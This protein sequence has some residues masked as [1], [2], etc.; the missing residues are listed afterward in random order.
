MALLAR[1]ADSLYWAG[2]Y[3]ERAEDTA[4]IV[5]SY[6]EAVVDLPRT[7]ATSW[8][9]LL[10]ITGVADAAAAGEHAIVRHLVADT[11]NPASIAA[12][13]AAAREN[14]RTTREVLPRDAWR[15]LNDLYLYVLGSIDDGVDR[16]SRSRVL[17]TVV[18]SSRR[19]D[20]IVDSCMSHDEAYQM[21]RLGRTIERADM[22]T[23]VLGVRAAALL[24]VGDAADF[25]G[26]LW[27]SVLRSLSA[28]QMYQRSS[29]R[30]VEGHAVV[31]FLLYD[32]HFPRSVRACL[33]QMR[34]Q[35]LALPSGHVVVAA[36]DDVD[37]ALGAAAVLGEGGAELD[38]AMDAV[39]LALGA[40]SDRL[41]A[42]YLRPSDHLVDR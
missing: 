32:E 26:V 39:Q 17:G 38:A 13:I 12:T 14:L 22:T 28:L 9:P 8:T 7:M 37:D 36:V 16:R 5:R 40:L 1:V 19:L 42:R 15:A 25:H 30:P 31:S 35:L 27:M 6:T 21:W 3:V 29:R 18:D 11:A 20:G 4:R 2:R 24:Q 34:D 33:I 10:A 23:R 41:T